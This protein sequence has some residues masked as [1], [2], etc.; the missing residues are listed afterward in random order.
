[1]SNRIVP[2]IT[3][4]CFNRVSNSFLESRIFC[5]D[6]FMST[7]DFLVNITACGK[8]LAR[9][10]IGIQF[11]KTL[12]NRN[13]IH[14]R[15]SR[16]CIFLQGCNN[17]YAICWPKAMPNFYFN[18][19][20]ST[21]HWKSSQTKR[22]CIHSHLYS[23]TIMCQQHFQIQ[24]DSTNYQ[25]KHAHKHTHTHIQDKVTHDNFLQES[26][27]QSFLSKHEL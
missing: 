14:C 1:M 18:P 20:S 21:K 13:I 16:K 3:R 10:H 25:D 15:G 22:I 9:S 5:A 23:F 2:R 24:I 4:R 19:C 26:T 12:A 27:R 7:C 17:C 6:F 8:N 11:Q